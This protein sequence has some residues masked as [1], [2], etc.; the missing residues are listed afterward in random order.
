MTRS[1]HLRTVGDQHAGVPYVV[2]HRA[3]E[4]IPEELRFIDDDQGNH[5][6]IYIFSDDEGAEIV[7]IIE[8]DEAEDSPP[9]S[10]DDEEE[11]DQNGD[12]LP[13][14]ASDYSDEWSNWSEFSLDSGY[15]SM[16]PE[17]DE[18][19]DNRDG[20][21][22]DEE[23]EGEEEEEFVI[24]DD[25]LELADFEEIPF[26]HIPASS[27]RSREESLKVQHAVKWQRTNE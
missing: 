22:G 8:D 2:D 9:F 1:K 6:P 25:N 23:S 12:M 18:D 5:P 7:V 13:R 27:K 17:A 4:E 16:S 3:A 20:P 24:Y 15:K 11:G 21:D 26:S 10:F 19:D 14:A